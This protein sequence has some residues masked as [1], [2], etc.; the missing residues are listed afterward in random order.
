MYSKRLISITVTA[1]SLTAFA[2]APVRYSCEMSGACGF[3]ICCCDLDACVPD[4]MSACGVFFSTHTDQRMPSTA[5][6]PCSPGQCTPISTAFFYPPLSSQHS[7]LGDSAVEKRP[8][9]LALSRFSASLD[10]APNRLNIPICRTRGPEF[11][12]PG[13]EI[14]RC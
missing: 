7:S 6:A 3:D 8:N 12:S 1:M 11:K 10:G 5:G 13:Y 4:G 2:Q 9:K 14:L